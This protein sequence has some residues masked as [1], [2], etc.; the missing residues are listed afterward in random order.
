MKGSNIVLR[1]VRSC[2][3][4][5]RSLWLLL[6]LAIGVGAA[7]PHGHVDSRLDGC[8]SCLSGETSR[9]RL[10][11]VL[12]GGGARGLCH[13]GAIRALEELEMP[14]D[15]VCGTSMGGVVGGLWAMGWTPQELDSLV[16]TLDWMDHFR[17]EP[18][19]NR[20]IGNAR[21]LDRPEHLRLAV[22][23]FRLKPPSHFVRGSKVELLL[24]DLTLGWQGPID[25]LGLPI[26][27][28]C[29]ATDL[30]SGEAV[31]LTEGD[32]AL[33]LRA[34]MSLPSIFEPVELE[35]RVLVDGGLVQNL[36]TD[37]ALRL[38]AERI[39]AVNLPTV[40]RPRDELEDLLSIADQ[41]RG[42]MTLATER[43]QERLAD[44]VIVPP[45]GSAG[46]LDFDAVAELVEA[47]YAETMRHRDALLA[48]RDSLQ[49][50]GTRAPGRRR[51][52]DRLMLAEVRVDGDTDLSLEQAENIL[53]VRAGEIFRPVDVSARV[54]DFV[55]SGLAERAGYAIVSHPAP[56]RFDSAGTEPAA[57]TL[58]VSQPRSTWLDLFI[59]YDELER[60][61]FGL[62][63][64]WQAPRGPGTALRLTTLLSGRTGVEIES[65]RS[66]Y[67]NSGLYVHPRLFYSRRLVFLHD[68]AGD[69]LA[70]YYD[71]RWGGGLG[72]GL[73][74]RRGARLEAGLRSEQALSVPDVAAQTWTRISQR[75]NGAYLRLEIDTRNTVDTPSSGYMFDAE[76]VQYGDL[77]GASESF[78]RWDLS[79]RGW[80]SFELRPL[81]GGP[82]DES[83]PSYRRGLLTLEPGF[84]AGGSRDDLPLQM[85]HE[86]GGW[87]GGA[88]F[89]RG[90]I[91]A[92][93][94]W[95]AWLG[96][97]LWGNSILSLMPAV[98]VTD[99]RR[100]VLGGDIRQQVG[101]GVELAARTLIGPLRLVVAGTE[102]RDPLL[103]LELGWR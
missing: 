94:Y 88:G 50:P 7:L 25:F 28:A 59:G 79:M 40:L 3:R 22:Q 64:D 87:P 68:M 58:S 80:H 82:R 65:W 38:G 33:A 90:E 95:T 31:Y 77:L 71:S 19:H 47:G 69:R 81:A 1:L 70:S 45:T 12:A 46:L 48:L 15:L 57:L 72:A 16:R 51:T 30:E 92:E 85:Y 20:L 26:P 41:S 23:G 49:R 97:R 78:G 75:F 53:G 43:S 44:L 103:L 99:A 24:D 9:P 2:A 101:W 52:A 37:L 13:V 55:A 17:D 60:A 39:I 89:E 86:T 67:L 96:M 61:V 102:S 56:A 14:V 84:G 62:R 5:L 83:S 93:Q 63:L 10:A 32:L 74:L 8:P 29:A 42:I 18:P 35:G 36:P 11:L 4:P 73:V 6:L 27:F 34:T 76:A 91:W 98:C 66:S 21:F 100:T 54:R